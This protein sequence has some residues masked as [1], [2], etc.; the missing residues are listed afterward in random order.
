MLV[1]SFCSKRHLDDFK[2]TYF[3]ENICARKISTQTLMIGS[4][5]S[6]FDK[7]HAEELRTKDKVRKKQLGKWSKRKP[8]SYLPIDFKMG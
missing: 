4:V 2:I 7:Q 1:T 3:K 6:T 8:P 5:A